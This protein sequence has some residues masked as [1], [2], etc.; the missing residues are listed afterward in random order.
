VRRR[1]KEAFA[2]EL[3]VSSLP[4][5]MVLT[6]R[7]FSRLVGPTSV[8]SLVGGLALLW[9]V[10]RPP[11]QSTGSFIGQLLGAESVLLMSI[12]LVLI[13][14]LPW[15]ETYFDGI[16]RAAIWHRRVGIVGI[17]L[18]LPHILLSSG[19]GT[20][21]GWANP[22]GTVATVGLVFLVVWAVLPRW[23]SVIPAPGRRVIL[24]V[25]E[26]PPVRLLSRMV[27]GYELWRAVHRT[28]GVFVAIGFAHGIASGT[29]FDRAPLLRWSYVT[30]GGIGLAFYV[31]RELLARRGHG[32]R[33]YQVQDVRALADDLTEIVLRPL[34][35]PLAYQPGQ[36]AMLHLES[37]DGW[38]RHPFTLASSPSEPN[39][40][41]TV[42]ALGDYTSSLADRVVP[43]MPAVL[44]GPHGRFLHSKGTTRQ[45]WVAG[46]VGL[47]PFLS[48]LRSLDEHPPP[49]PVHFFYT[50]TDDAPYADE[51]R[52]IVDRHPQVDLRI[53][54]TIADP[55]LTADALLE[56][57]GGSVT[58][59]SVFMCGPTQMVSSLTSGLRR[60]G[61]PNS[62]IHR[63]HFDW[64]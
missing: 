34:G 42:K 20:A 53:V 36:F 12:G 39:V 8:I 40:R 63:E 57:V 56:P 62:S 26:W 18:L 22:A 46:G 6:S 13:T 49:G 3:S 43:G 1:L 44:S 35:K 60:A 47:T 59:V 5:D 14:T 51:I 38:H 48:W 17:L 4:C 37:K 21:P 19:Q 64:R 61:V 11:G 58:D 41:V 16:D 27:S 45:I 28:T 2:A 33:D 29:P 50:V 9:V 31:Y 32:L 25:H 10:G 23:R 30:I 55:R 7:S 24:R 15:V 54:R 52:D